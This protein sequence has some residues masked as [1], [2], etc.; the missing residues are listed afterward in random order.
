M[1]CVAV[2]VG[3]VMPA[4]AEDRTRTERVDAIF[5]WYER[6]EQPGCAVGI[7][8]RGRSVFIRGYGVADLD[9]GV[10]ITRDSVFDIA[11]ASKQ[12]TAA[13]VYLLAAD[14]LLSLSD[15]VRAWVPELPAYSTSP[16]L[17]QL[18]HHVSGLPD[19]TGLLDVPYSA[20]TTTADAL[21]ALA[22]ERIPNAATGYAKDGRRF[23]REVSNWMQTGDGAAT[24]GGLSIDS[25]DGQ[26]L[27]E[28]SGAWAGFTS[29]VVA[30]PE[31]RLGV[32]VL[33][34]RDDAD[35]ERLARRVLRVWRSG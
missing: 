25:L 2:I 29:D 31:E 6:G 26:L 32:A 17:D 23:D 35:P 33:C 8:E 27:V 4:G 30:L 20:R 18:V 1:V 11:S 9:R 7:G 19:Y 10:P 28:H 14:G 21:R 16:T 22:D 15:D 3:P 24:A 12:I 34:N 13:M 5:A